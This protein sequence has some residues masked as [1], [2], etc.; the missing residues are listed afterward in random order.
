MDSV[1]ERANGTT[2]LEISKSNFRSMLV[3]LPPKLL[4]DGWM[5]FAGPL[6]GLVV[7]ME[8][9][10]QALIALRDT[11]LPKLVS[12]ELRVRQAESLVEAAL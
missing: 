1:K 9:E 12:G 4:V 7:S 10:T 11:L 6:Y 3:A 8:R 5:E 2:F